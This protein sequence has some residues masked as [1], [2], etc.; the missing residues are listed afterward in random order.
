MSDAVR[1]GI[2]GDFNPEFRSHHA[3][4]ESLQH[5]AA[6]LNLPV[7]SAWISTPSVLEPNAQKML[8][9]F[10]GI[11]AAPGSPYESF[12]GMLKGIEF[13]RRRDWPFLGTCGGF[14]YTLIECARNVLGIKD[15]DTAENNSGSKNIVIY[16]VACAVPDR[17]EDAA[18]LSGAIPEIRL[19]PGSYLQSFYMKDTVVEEFF[20]NFEVNPDYEWAAMEAG[21]PVVARGPQGEIRAIESPTHLFYIATLFQPQLSSKPKKPHPLVL[22]FVQ[23]AMDWNRKRLDDSILV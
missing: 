10:D 15:A 19:R 8:E 21:F 2:L 17:A 23:A 9:S 5:V 3:T 1:I 11:W 7:E 13:A 20:C 6:K 22:A 16:P 14:Q 18:K 12:D 4:N